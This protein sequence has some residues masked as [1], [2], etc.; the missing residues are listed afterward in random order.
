MKRVIMLLFILYLGTFSPA[1]DKCFTLEQ[2]ILGSRDE[3]RIENL[4]G[5]QWMGESNEFC[6]V[7][8]LNDQYGLIKGTIDS[9]HMTM[10]LSLDSLNKALSAL[11]IDQLRRFP[12]IHWTEE[13]SFYFLESRKL[14]LYDIREKSGKI[15]NQ[16]TEDA[17]HIDIEPNTFRIAFTRKEDLFISLDTGTEIQVTYDGGNGISNGNSYVH[18][19]EFG[20]HDGIFW[21][22]QGKKVAFYRKDESMVTEY[23]LVE[24]DSRPATLRTT[25]YPMAGMVSERVTVGIYDIK[26]GSVTYLQ[27]G[28]PK[29]HYLPQVTWGPD[30]SSIFIT[31]LNRDQ[32]HL[33]L[34]EYD[35]YTGKVIRTI[36]EE[37]DEEWIEPTHGPIFFKNRNNQFVWFSR[38]DGFNQFYLYSIEGK[39][40]KQ[41]THARQDITAFSGF[42]DAE[43]NIF[44]TAASPDGMQRHAFRI[45]IRSGKIRQ[46]TSSPGM[47]RIDPSSQ[48][49]YCIDHFSSSIVPR[50]I[51]LLGKNGKEARVLLDAENP[52]QDY[53]LGEVTFLS[54]ENQQGTEL[55]A[56]MI[57]PVDFNPDKKYPVI[58]YVYGGPHGQMITDH[59][60]SGWRLWFHYMAQRG[61]IVFSMDNRGTNN[62]GV[63]FEQAI[64]RSLGTIEVE[65]QM[66]GVEYL[67]SVEYVDKE[68]IGVHGWSYG[69]FM[70][71]SLMTRRPGVFKAA[72]AGGPVIDWRYY[73]VMYGERY[74]DTPQANPEGYK[75]SNLLNYVDN[76]EGKLLL[77]HGTLDPTV[78]WQHSLLYLRKAIDLGKQVDYFVYPGDGHNMGGKDRVH[79]Y[80]QITDYF[81]DNL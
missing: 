51:T 74:M 32:N 6:Y 11:N 68:R 62:R 81:E 9:D 46:L 34:K 33:Q 50:K 28:Q 27:T 53:S 60:I 26:S 71:I 73:E 38:R 52:I 45:N 44:Y 21:S 31:H 16:V 36:L 13:K 41:L 4:S 69:G 2:A 59:W 56:R 76:L 63:A 35:P 78:V 40:I 75:E 49:S 12:S 20:I 10:L 64:F 22:P 7:D 47:H 29:D 61:Y 23:P 18:R 37:K 67:K 24:I 8:T 58:I 42:D 14:V 48:G 54:L 30:G 65:D 43:D 15:V 19:A 39:L 66:V 80:Q 70:S 79:L 17:A 55:H 57:L 25:R 72:V 77:I 3:F 1:Q 5:L